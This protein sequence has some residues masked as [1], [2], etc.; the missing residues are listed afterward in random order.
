MGIRLSS[1]LIRNLKSPFNP[2]QMGTGGTNMPCDRYRN[3][4]TMRL[5]RVSQ[6]GHWIRLS[7]QLIRNLKSPFNPNTDGHRR[8]QYALRQVQEL[9]YHASHP[10]FSERSLDQTQFAVDSQFEVA[11]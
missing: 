7:S 1:Q 8:H 5:I 6:N 4:R 9:S 11:V 3:C 10:R 2:T